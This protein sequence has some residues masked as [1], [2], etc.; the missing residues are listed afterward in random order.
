VD[1]VAAEH[2][3]LSHEARAAVMAELLTSQPEDRNSR[4]TDTAVHDLNNL[5][6]YTDTPARFAQVSAA[7]TA[8]VREQGRDAAYALLQKLS[9][10]SSSLRDP[11]RDEMLLQLVQASGSLNAGVEGVDL[12]RIRVKDESDAER[13]QLFLDIAK[14]SG[15]EASAL[16]RCLL[17]ERLPDETLGQCGA[18]LLKLAEA[19]SLTKNGE[20]TADVFAYLQCHSKDAAAADA[21]VDRLTSALV[22][23]RSLEDALRVIASDR[24]HGVPAGPS[25]VERGEE[26]VI[27]GGIR[28]PKSE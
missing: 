19:M 21:A 22:V 5:V 27:I 24:D 15:K 13:L 4:V 7:F 11:A 17:A 8:T 26:A 16:Y 10:G 23:S 20:H 2:P 3:T 1:A 12:V 9:K 14:S 28:I 6:K 18:R 25:T